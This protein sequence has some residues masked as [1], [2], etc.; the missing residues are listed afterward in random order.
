MGY[1]CMMSLS[2]HHTS[3]FLLFQS[4]FVTTEEV[5]MIFLLEKNK[6]KFCFAN[7]TDGI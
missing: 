1:A 5:F 3:P 4:L 2:T 6:L 7:K